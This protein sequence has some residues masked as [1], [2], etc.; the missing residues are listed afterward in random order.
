M[1]LYILVNDQDNFD[2]VKTPQAAEVGVAEAA[3]AGGER[4]RGKEEPDQEELQGEDGEADEAARQRVAV[5]GDRGVAGQLQP[6]GAA[7]R[8]PVRRQHEP[9]AGKR[10]AERPAQNTESSG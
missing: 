2:I 3:E 7:L 1:Y 9:D 6:R 4:H 10:R 8:Q 5:Q